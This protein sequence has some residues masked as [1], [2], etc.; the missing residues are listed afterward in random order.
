MSQRELKALTEKGDLTQEKRLRSGRLRT[1]RDDA[2]AE[3]GS[4]ELEELQTQLQEARARLEAQSRELAD[5]QR[6][7]SDAQSEAE[8]ARQRADE[9]ENELRATALQ[10]ELDKLRALETLREKFDEEREKLRDDR[11]QDGARFSEWKA[12]A[13]A[14]KGEL[15][16]QVK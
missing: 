7:M 3:E 5:A 4:S 11:A 10:A 12:T 1:R 9:L 16:E 6:G 13:D 14:E 15:T 2:M 8:S